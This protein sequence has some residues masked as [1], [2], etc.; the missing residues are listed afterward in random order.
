M[1]ARRLNYRLISAHHKT[2]NSSKE[3]MCIKVLVR[4]LSELTKFFRT[5]PSV[6]MSRISFL[7]HQGLNSIHLKT[8]NGVEGK[9][10]PI[11]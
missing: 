6:D 1:C 5:N 10:H 9:S 2:T 8:R 4:G 7:S 11:A 3:H